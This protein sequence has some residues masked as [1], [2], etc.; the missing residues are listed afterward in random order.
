MSS[1]KIINWVFGIVIAALVGTAVTA[2]YLNQGRPSIQEAASSGASTS[3]LPQDHPPLELLTHLN[4]LEQLSLANPQNADY[5]TEIGNIYYD[6]GRYQN[7]LDAYE[8]SLKLKPRDPGVS[9]DAATCY[10][11]I[12]QDDKALEL[13]DEV[14]RFSPNFSQALFNKGVILINGKGDTAAGI[15]VWEE[16]LRTNPNF[17]QRAELEDQIRK[18]RA[19]GR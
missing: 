10:H 7:A 3:G 8:K 15:A 5:M 14:L 4:E 17:P 6:L 16:L 12:G 19:S 1:R 18:F 2:L 9:T 13:L 11:N